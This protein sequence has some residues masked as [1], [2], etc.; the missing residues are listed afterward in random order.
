MPERVLTTTLIKVHEVV[1][2]E[3][4]PEADFNDGIEE[5]CL[6]QLRFHRYNESDAKF[7][8]RCFYSK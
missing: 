7:Y 6:S 8:C 4:R 3:L 1:N 2:Q 5:D